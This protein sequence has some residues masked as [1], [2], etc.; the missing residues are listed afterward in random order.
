MWKNCLQHLTDCEQVLVTLESSDSNS[1]VGLTCPLF[2]GVSSN[3]SYVLLL[4]L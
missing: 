1:K 3:S 4:S 2:L